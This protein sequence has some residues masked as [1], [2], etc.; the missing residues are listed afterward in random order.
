VTENSKP[1]IVVGV[2]GSTESKAALRWAGQLAA[3]YGARLDVVAVWEYAALFGITPAAEFEFPVQDIEQSLEETLNEVFGT[4]RPA[5]IRVKALEGSA[6]DTLVTVAKDALMIVVGSRGRGGLTGMLLGSVSAK[7]AAE[8]TC[9][10]LI[11]HGYAPPA[12][13]ATGA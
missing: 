7:V 9:P 3:T 10:A 11:V 1:R 8:A 5:D 13:P 4:G 2:D 6:A 12:R